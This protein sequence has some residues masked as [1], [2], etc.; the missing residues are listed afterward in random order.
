M[1]LGLVDLGPRR[2]RA[3]L[4]SAA[5]T[6]LLLSAPE[7]ESRAAFEPDRDGRVIVRVQPELLRGGRL[8]VTSRLTA[9]L[10]FPVLGGDPGSP[11]KQS[12]ATPVMPVS[13]VTKASTSSR[14]AALPSSRR[15]RAW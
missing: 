6:V 13:G 3:A 1:N 12:S 11:A 14:P 4:W 10:L 7:G 8:R 2:R 9:T 5:V 15:A